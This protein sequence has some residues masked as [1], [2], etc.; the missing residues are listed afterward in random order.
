MGTPVQKIVEELAGVRAA[1]MKQAFMTQRSATKI[2]ELRE[3][4]RGMP[5][6]AGVKVRVVPVGSVI[7]GRGGNG[8]VLA[9]E[10]SI[11]FAPEGSKAHVP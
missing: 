10:G 11:V 4:G 9:D 1:P 7:V 5:W 3:A 6:L 8:V 2:A